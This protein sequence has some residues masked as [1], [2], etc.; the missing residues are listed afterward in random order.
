MLYIHNPDPLLKSFM[1]LDPRDPRVEL[2][3]GFPPAHLRPGSEP[4]SVAK[5]RAAQR[6]ERIEALERLHHDDLDGFDRLLTIFH[7]DD[8]EL[9]FEL[10]GRRSFARAA[11]YVYEMKHGRY[12]R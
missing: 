2:P 7:A 6:R 3:V 11:I 9:Y 12:L 5:A 10:P 4:A 1:S 8:P